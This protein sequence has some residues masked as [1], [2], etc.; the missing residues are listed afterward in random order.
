MVSAENG[1]Y[2]GSQ[3]SLDVNGQ[4]KVLTKGRQKEKAE[5]KFFHKHRDH[6]ATVKLGTECPGDRCATIT[7]Q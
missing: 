3:S 1:A 5:P 4:K 2:S 6:T 7:R